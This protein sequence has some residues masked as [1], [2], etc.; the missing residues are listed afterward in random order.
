[1]SSDTF[2]LL[3]WSMIYPLKTFGLK[4]KSPLFWVKSFQPHLFDLVHTSRNRFLGLKFSSSVSGE[5]MRLEV[6]NPKEVKGWNGNY[7][8]RN[9]NS[10]ITSLYL[11]LILFWKKI[12]HW[13]QWY[14]VVH[15]I[16]QFA[17]YKKEIVMYSTVD[18]HCGG[19]I[20]RD[21]F[22]YLTILDLLFRSPLFFIYPK[23]P[24]LVP[25]NLYYNIPYLL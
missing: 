4:I 9:C 6:P 25:K 17:F 10:Y 19:I 15:Q 14:H 3:Q 8:A 18:H 1:M 21:G 7:S 24:S 20:I 22:N 5:C 13:K 12:R 11:K 23:A 16:S 2:L